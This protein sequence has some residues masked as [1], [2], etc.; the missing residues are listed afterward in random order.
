MIPGNW[1]FGTQQ[2]AHEFLSHILVNSYQSALDNIFQFKLNE[3]VVCKS[4]ICNQRICHNKVD[5]MFF[6][7]LP[8]VETSFPQAI[9]FFIHQYQ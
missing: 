7:D 2:D 9:V 1:A 3:S 6:L 4:H 8:I 5:S